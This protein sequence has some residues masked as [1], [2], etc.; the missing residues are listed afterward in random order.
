MRS[1]AIRE[2]GLG[3]TQETWMPE[4]E[5]DTGRQLVLPVGVRGNRLIHQSENPFW[6]V[7]HFYVNV[8]LDVLI[9]R[10]LVK[11]VDACRLGVALYALLTFISRATV[12]A[13]VGM[14]C[15]GFLT[16]RTCSIPFGPYQSLSR[17]CPVNGIM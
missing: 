8:K 9:L 11:H 5:D 6:V 14:A 10:L 4:S 13:N 16:V 1:V 7:V 12:S 3:S 15:L 17:I 2:V